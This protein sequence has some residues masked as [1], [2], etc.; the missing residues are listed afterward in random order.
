MQ[1]LMSVETQ[2]Q[3]IHRAMYFKGNAKQPLEQ[4]NKIAFY[5]R[6]IKKIKR[7]E[8]KILKV[9]NIK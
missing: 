5:S 1:M 9:S 6:K 2:G 4:Q 7:T 3:W 8:W